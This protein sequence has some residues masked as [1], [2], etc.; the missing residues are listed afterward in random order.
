[1]V[2]DCFTFFNELDMLEIRMSILDPHVDFFVICESRKT[3]SGKDKPLYYDDNKE[4]FAKWKDKIIH[5]VE[6]GRDFPNA[7]NAAAF[8]KDGIR[9]ALARWYKPADDAI[10]YFGDVDEIWKPQDIQDDKVYNLRQLN[11]CYYLNNRSSEQWV[12]TVVGRWGTI[13]TNTLNYW[14]ATHTNELD[15][16]G[17]HFT[18]MGGAEQI[19]KKLEAY[20]HQEYNTDD[21][22]G[23]IEER[24]ASGQDY[25]GRGRDWRGVPFEMWT[26][27]SEL[28]AYLLE[29]KERYKHL[30]K[31]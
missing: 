13:K 12:G 19:R 22:K 30:F 15:D 23:R 2:Y 21:V 8:Q 16:G 24:M 7:F 1:M 18:N 10:I 9:K 25:V 14:R 3:F 5:L 20:D 4:R 28:P 11:Y 17:W 6:K 29:N 31:T 26:D 27:E